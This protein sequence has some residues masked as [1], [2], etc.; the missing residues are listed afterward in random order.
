MRAIGAPLILSMP[1]T[2]MSPL[3]TTLHEALSC[4]QSGIYARTHTRRT[5]SAARIDSA[6]IRC[7]INFFW[8][9]RMVYNGLAPNPVSLKTPLNANCIS[10][11]STQRKIE[12]TEGIDTSA[13]TSYVR[14]KYSIIYRDMFSAGK[15]SKFPMQPLSSIQCKR[16]RAKITHEIY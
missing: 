1:G 7:I 10:H 9:R 12:D 2:V 15:A 13:P 5:L 14:Y 8:Q 4:V 6:T 16:V 3:D 11:T